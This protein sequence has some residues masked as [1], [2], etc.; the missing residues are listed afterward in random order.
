M[1]TEKRKST[2]ASTQL[3]PEKLAKTEKEKTEKTEKT[4]TNGVSNGAVKTTSNLA[5]SNSSTTNNEEK[6]Q[7]SDLLRLLLHTK[8]ERFVNPTNVVFVCF[9]E[10]KVVDVWKGLVKHNFLSCPVLQKTEN[11]YYGS[12]DIADIVSYL[13]KKFGTEEL[14]GSEAFWQRLDEAKAFG[15]LTVGDIIQSP[16]SRRNPFHPVSEGYSLLFAIE[17]LARESDLHRVPVI[18][19]RERKLVNMIT[20]SQI[21]DFLHKHLNSFGERTK[22]TLA[23]FPQFFKE[24]HSAKETALAI[25]AF[26]NMVEHDISGV[27]IV[28][29]EGRL[30]GNLSLRDLKSVGYDLNLFWRFYQTVENYVLKLRKEYQEKHGRPRHVVFATKEDTLG[31]VINTLA[32]NHIHRL[33][34]VD[35]KKEKKPIGVVSLK[36]ILTEVLDL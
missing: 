30:T 29:E 20:Q 23:D 36:D 5:P 3:S 8:V 21:I 31:F 11:K 34:I 26:T 10:D 4:A 14:R 22:K 32:E 24:V 27:A 33:Y 13:V 17:L 6:H 9:R 35:S 2:T 1:S 7:E 28:N 18:S 16:M 15:A 19:P 12:I 25:D